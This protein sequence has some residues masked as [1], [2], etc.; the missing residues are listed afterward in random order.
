MTSVP[1]FDTNP[2][3]PLQQDLEA[4]RLAHTQAL[5]HAAKWRQRYELEAQQRCQEAD[6]A[7]QT[8]QALRLEVQQLC[9]LRPQDFSPHAL[10][11]STT[12]DTKDKLL[13][14][15]GLRAQLEAVTAERDQLAQALAAEKANHAQT[16]ANLI[17][18]LNDAMRTR[19]Q[20]PSSEIGARVGSVVARDREQH[21]ARRSQP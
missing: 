14:L 9:Q 6:V 3:Q 4:A 20:L 8:I 7:Q 2:C 16:R 18:A 17:N 21:R 15:E 10:K 1:P 5:A 13:S 19:P 11:P 12:G